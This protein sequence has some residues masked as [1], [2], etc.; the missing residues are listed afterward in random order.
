MG[1]TEF[2]TLPQHIVSNHTH[3]TPPFLAQN[4]SLDKK[5][6]I[7]RYEHMLSTQGTL[8]SLT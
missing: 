4:H 3:S 5:H 8:S 6:K 7:D 1:G 2:V